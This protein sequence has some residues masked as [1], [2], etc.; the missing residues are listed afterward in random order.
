VLVAART[1]AEVEAV[2][3]SLRAEGYKA[4]AAVCDVTDAAS[5]EALAQ[6]AASRLGPVDI[7]VNNAG[8]SSSAPLQRLAL[9]EWER[10]FAVNATG[11]LLCTQAFLPAMV[12]R[13]W[14]RVV[15]IA[16]VVGLAGG[17]Y[18]AAYSASKHA[19]VGLT[20]S[21]AAEVAAAG[22]TVNAICPGY[23]DTGMTRRS[24]ER[25]VEKTGRS[26]DE[27]RDAILSTSPQH[28]LIAPEEVAHL[29]LALCHEHAR[30]INGQA[31]VID[32]GGLVA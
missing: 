27:A 1:R 25:I 8:A 15:N 22:V 13:G 29:V 5:V 16:S 20:R 9:E 2:A 28:R 17:K 7:L 24:I 10:L 21:V 30:G 18:I 11:T 3:A 4:H 26:A 12:E 6:E 31:I 32:G 23:V 14:G 19:V